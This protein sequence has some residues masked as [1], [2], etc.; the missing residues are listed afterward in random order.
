M[1]A[2]I[3]HMKNYDGLVVSLSDTDWYDLN[4]VYC[5]AENNRGQSY[6]SLDAVV[7]YAFEIG[8]QQMKDDLETQL[9][10][11]SIVQNQNCR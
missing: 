6:D 7:R 3:K 5:L 11:K 2:E 10:L 9:T 4:L 8:I 1:M